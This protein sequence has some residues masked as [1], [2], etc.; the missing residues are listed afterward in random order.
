MQ[1]YNLAINTKSQEP[2]IILLEKA[3]AHFDPSILDDLA[4][5]LSDANRLYATNGRAGVIATLQALIKCCETVPELQPGLTPLV[6]VLAALSDLDV[7][8]VS[9]ITAATAF[10][11]RPP[12]LAYRKVVKSVALACADMLHRSGMS[13]KQADGRVAAHLEK[14]G[15]ELRGRPTSSGATVLTGW[16]QSLSRQDAK[17]GQSGYAFEAFS[18]LLCMR[19][20]TSTREAWSELANELG[21]LVIGMRPALK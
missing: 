15:F 18:A 6:A 8:V 5:A 20:Y 11:N 14:L 2:S 3:L 13:R 4:S 16:R 9:Q 12:D 1:H 19:K 7:G 10:G 21:S 17:Y